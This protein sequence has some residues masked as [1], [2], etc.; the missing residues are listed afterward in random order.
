MTKIEWTHYTAT[1]GNVVRGATLNPIKGC[2][3]AAYQPVTGGPKQAHP[4][5]T[6]CYAEGFCARNMHGEA[7]TVGR[8]DGTIEFYLER[9][10]WPFVKPGFRTRKDGMPTIVF[11]CSESDMGH[12]GLDRPV[13][14]IW[15][16]GRKRIELGPVDGIE[17]WKAING[18][19]LLS[20]HIIWKDLTKRPEIQ[21]ERLDR[22]GPAKC[23]DAVADIIGRALTDHTN[24]NRLRIEY[25]LKW[26]D[27]RHIH[28]YVS[29]SDQATADA[30][31]PELLRIPAAVRGVSAEPLLGPVD[32]SGWLNRTQHTQWGCTRLP[33]I[34]HA[35]IGGESGRGARPFDLAWA[36]DVIR[37]CREAGV[38][39]YMKQTGNNPLGFGEHI[40]IRKG[41]DPLEWPEDLRVRE[42]V[43]LPEGCR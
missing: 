30:L 17:A 5:C 7:A 22:W 19:M 29:V 42:H 2:S 40:I 28:R 43:G 33:S 35:I 31:I 8:W 34:D 11:L 23:V 14:S 36:R 26:E 12:P 38:P 32:L 41:S 1:G 6:H 15:M 4:G 37:Q 9:L 27:A 21:Q 3:H 18:M 16:E 39:V 25:P 10:A 24:T 20:P 13:M